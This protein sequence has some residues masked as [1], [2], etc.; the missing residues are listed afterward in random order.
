LDI[1]CNHIMPGF[2]GPSLLWVKENEPFIFDGISK[3]LLPKDYIRFKLTGSFATDASDASATLLFDVKRI[4]WSCHLFSQ[5]DISQELFPKVFK[6]T[7]VTGEISPETSRATGLPR[8]IPVVAGGGDSP[9]G[10]VGCG[11]IKAGI[12]SSNIGTGGK[13]FNTLDEFTVDPKYRIHTFCHA[14]PGKW[15][16][17]GAILPAGLSLRWFRDNFAHLE[18]SVGFLCNVD[19]YDLLSK[20][21]EVA[22]PGCG[23]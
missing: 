10:A 9:V 13:I 22:E 6:S 16:L 15:Y 7:D 5:L 20:E 23:G 2:M 12:V 17:Q 21:A 1:V 19:P 11:A 8:L 4:E 18:K 3:V 14:V